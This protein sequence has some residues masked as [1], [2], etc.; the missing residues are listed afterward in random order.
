MIIDRKKISFAILLFTI[1]LFFIILLN[2]KIVIAEVYNWKWYSPYNLAISPSM[3]KLPPLIEEKTNG[4]I[5]VTLYVGGQ[6]PFKG[7][8]MP[9]AIKSGAAQMAD[10][11]PAYCVGMEPRFGAAD[12]PFF[13][14]SA[15]EEDQLIANVLKEVYE[16]FFN[17]YGTMPLA[18]YP[19]P[20][21]AIVADTLVTNLDSLKGKKIRVF[22]KTS[23]DMIATMGGT[24]IS[25][26][27]SEIYPAL[28]RGVV[29]GAVGSTFG[30]LMMKTVE[31]AKYL[32]RT[33]AYARGNSYYVTVSKSEFNKL[34]TELQNKVREAFREYEA[35]ARKR[36]H[37]IDSLAV[38]DIIDKY[39]GTVSSIGGTFR[40]KIREKMKEGCWV[41]WAKTFPEGME[42]LNRMEEF[43]NKWVKT[44]K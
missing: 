16:N 24:P 40:Q 8:D 4:Q 44:Q 23:S 13:T 2:A 26:P 31:V 1:S 30:Q 21:Q 33:H 12:L 17:S 25:I 19:F 36:Q 38:T 18:S 5:K 32:T 9:R 10:I 39:G 37:E 20:G 34:P 7:P 42:L 28:Q 6:H 22:N 27:F 35:F 3:D 15:E 43:H 14:N 11:L 29:D 41:K